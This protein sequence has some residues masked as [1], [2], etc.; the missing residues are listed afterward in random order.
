MEGSLFANQL[1]P[2][3]QNQNM[4]YVSFFEE[5]NRR[6][7]LFSNRLSRQAH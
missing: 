3:M 2:N 7:V 1:F 6:S 4:N 5:T